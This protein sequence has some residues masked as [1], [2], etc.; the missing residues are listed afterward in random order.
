[1]NEYEQD[2]WRIIALKVGP[3]FTPA[4]CREKS[5]EL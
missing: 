4:A 2:R 5:K 3:G 1:M